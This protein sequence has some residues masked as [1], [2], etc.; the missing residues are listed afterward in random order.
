MRQKRSMPSIIERVVKGAIGST[1]A[2]AD[3]NARAA[4]CTAAAVSGSTASPQPASISK[5]MRRPFGS[6]RNCVQSIAAGGRLIVS[7]ASG[8][9]STCISSA[10]SSTLRV[11]GPA[12]R[13]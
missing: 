6:R 9:D 12:T 1:I 8:C 13:P 2:P 11:I 3:S 4:A 7:R 5:P 10:V